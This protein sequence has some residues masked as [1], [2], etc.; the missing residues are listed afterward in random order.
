MAK[1]V[2]I[3]GISI[4][5]QETSGKWSSTELIAEDLPRLIAS[6]FEILRLTPSEESPDYKEKDYSQLLIPLAEFYRYQ[7]RPVVTELE[8]QIEELELPGSLEL[9]E[10]ISR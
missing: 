5:G 6:N 1:E 2:E 3:R 10:L 4:I 8:K 9:E 7:I